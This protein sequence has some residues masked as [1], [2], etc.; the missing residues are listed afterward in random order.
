MKSFK[1]A[2]FAVAAAMFAVACCCGGGNGSYSGP[3]LSGHRG[4][5]YLAP[6]NTM[7]AIDSAIVLGVEF[8]EVDVYESKDGVLYIIHD[9]T[10]D[11]TTNG[12][13]YIANLNSSYIDTLDAGEWYGEEFR[14]LSVPRLRDVLRRAKEG[15]VKLTL[16][17]RTGDLQKMYDMIVEEEMLDNV[18][19]VMPREAAYRKF[20]EIAPD[21]KGMQAYVSGE[22]SMERDIER[23]NP[24]V[25]VVW[26]DSLT[27]NLVDK[28]HEKNIKV[29][30]L[31]LKKE[32]PDTMGYNKCVRLGVDVIATD[33]PDYYAKRR[34]GSKCCR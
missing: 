29:L 34:N 28:L 17:Y 3:A 2:I 9:R 25:A 7:A 26:T 20:R 10:M 6:E 31:S 18:T 27:Q 1:R 12:T 14:G 32:D 24:D 23:W 15:G 30:A 8:A 5:P 19:Y 16:D 33:R 21:V 13:G 4:V 11:R 22:S